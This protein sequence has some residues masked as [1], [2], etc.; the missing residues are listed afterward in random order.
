M[1]SLRMSEAAIAIGPAKAGRYR[2][3]RVL[4]AGRPEGLHYF[5]RDLAMRSHSDSSESL[6]IG[7]FARRYQ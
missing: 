5:R 1:P 6:A 3:R 2:N 7:W 4:T